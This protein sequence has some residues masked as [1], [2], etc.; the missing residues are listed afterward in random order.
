MVSAIFFCRQTAESGP[1]CPS[2]CW[3]VD[4]TWKP[5]ICSPL[6]QTVY[7]MDLLLKYGLY[8]L[9]RPQMKLQEKVLLGFVSATQKDRHL[10]EIQTTVWCCTGSS[11]KL[12]ELIY[13]DFRDFWIC[14]VFLNTWS[15]SLTVQMTLWDELGELQCL[16]E[17]HTL[18]CPERD[19]DINVN[20][21]VVD[22]SLQ[23]R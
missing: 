9:V 15:I 20:P 18:M 21:S 14:V 11:S 2:R 10:S 19:L 8:E 16:S 6:L 4:V 12:K 7:F 3:D 17:S 13:C 5:F 23:S 22:V 1:G